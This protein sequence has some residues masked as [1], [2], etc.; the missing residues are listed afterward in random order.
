MNRLE[1]ERADPP[2]ERLVNI[3][4]SPRLAFSSTSQLFVD[5]PLQSPA[6]AAGKA[7]DLERVVVKEDCKH[8]ANIGSLRLDIAGFFYRFFLRNDN[9]CINQHVLPEL[10]MS[11][12]G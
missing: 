3:W 2:G 5:D 8:Q 1:E 11:N 9:S 12:L 10:V 7:P 4:P 6:L